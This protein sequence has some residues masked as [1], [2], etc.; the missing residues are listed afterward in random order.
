MPVKKKKY[1]YDIVADQIL[2]EIKKGTW[3]VG[4]KL[5]PES[6][7]VEQYQVS[8]VC[9]RESLKKLNMLGILRIVQGDGTYVDEVNLEEFMKPLFSLM[10]ISE[11]NIEEIYDARI[12]VEGGACALAAQK[13]TPEELQQLRDIL[14]QMD[15]ALQQK[16]YYRYSEYDRQFHDLI[17]SISRNQ[18]LVMIRGMFRDVV[19]QYVHSIN[20]TEEVVE[21][22]IVDHRQLLWAIEDKESEFSKNILNAHM[23]RSKKV[24]LA[25]VERSL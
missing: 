10:A 8:R 6:K 9:L 3:K 24:M 18:I 15:N 22:S 25:R 12:L 23:E 2:D 17:T 20:T 13:R 19:D 21:K 4:D 5:P 11:K 14:A 1:K 7:L 16:D